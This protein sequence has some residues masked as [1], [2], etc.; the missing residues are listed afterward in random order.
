[1]GYVGGQALVEGV[2]MKGDKYVSRAVYTPAGDLLVDKH[3]FHSISEKIVI[4]KLPILRGFISL[5]DMLKM[6]MS[7]LLYSVNISSKDEEK[8]SKNEM[9]SSLLISM[10]FS[11]ALF[12]VMPAVFFTYL[13][14]HFSS[15]NIILLNLSEGL[16][17]IS[18]F[19]SFLISTIFMKDMRSVYEFHGAEHKAVNAYESGAN[20][21][22]TEVQKYSRIHTRC[23]TSFLMVVLFVSVF[24]FTFIGRQ[25]VFTRIGLKLLLLPLISGISYEIIRFAAKHN[26]NVFLKVLLLPGLLIQRITTKNPSDRQVEAAIAA[27][28]EVV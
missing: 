27:L 13:K 10:F 21:S 8:I 7:A 1:M 24:V 14:N 2:L 25:S 3:D 11:V 28:Q 5:I 12:V 26:K 16:F 22:V 6:G 23:G 18:V 17:R 4:F 20:L 15:M 19:L 9:T